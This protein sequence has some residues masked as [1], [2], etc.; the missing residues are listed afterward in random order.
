MRRLSRSWNLAGNVVH[1][2][3]QIARLLREAQ[4]A[5]CSCDGKCAVCLCAEGVGACPHGQLGSCDAC[6]RESDFAFDV[7]R[8]SR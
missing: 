2:N 3:A 7:R 8:E 1:R 5:R 4:A 6:D